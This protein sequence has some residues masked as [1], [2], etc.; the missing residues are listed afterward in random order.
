MKV[1]FSHSLAGASLLSL[2]CA[3]ALAETL[4]INADTSNPAPKA[5]FTEIVEQFDEA[6]PDLDVEL[7]ITDREAYKTAIRG[8]LTGS[9]PDVVLWYA[10]NRMNTFASRGLL[11]DVSDVWTENEL[12]EDFASTKASLTLDGKQYGVPYS[13]YQWGVYYR[14]DLFEEAGVEIPKTF[15][16]L[17]DA[18]TA[19]RENGVTPVAIGTKF[20]WTAAGWF[21]YLN[22][23]T[24]GL[25]FHLQLM[26]GE[27][28]YTDDRVRKTFGNWKRLIDADCFL[29]NHA[30]YSWQEAQPFLYNG[31]AAMYL[32]GN[33]I[34][35][36]FPEDV[37]E[38]I[39][40][41]QF[42]VIDESVGMTEDAPTDTVHIPARAKNKEGARRFLAYITEP[43]VQ[44]KI[45]KALNQLPPNA[46]AEV[47]DDR[48]L[49]Q[50]LE[51]LS[52]ADGTA[53][54]YDRDTPPE[55]AKIGMQGFQEFMVKP[56]N[57]DRILDRLEK[58]RQRI[59]KG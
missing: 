51:M 18:C 16:A 46:S 10:G 44:T 32:I 23:R 48:F 53:Q 20:L 21:D 27:V 26:K 15:D 33:F 17:V 55:M 42:P 38:N 25:D 14:K 58:A 35:P 34:T 30:S 12:S 37:A 5:A 2:V 40:F 19:L 11:D 1:P 56:E 31:D 59:F 24:N 57:L 54:F 7:N 36:N 22:M 9:P 45:N 28:P 8:W 3:P 6:N 41:F 29:D 39:G 4:V 43:D 13:Y 49:Q 52:K 50:G 47:G